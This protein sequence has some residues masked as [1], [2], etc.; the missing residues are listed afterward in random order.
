MLP[1]QINIVL[2][3]DDIDD[4]QFFK[5]ALEQL[6][7]TTHLTTVENGEEL[8]LLLSKDPTA[9][10]VVFLDLNMPRKNGFS[11][12][13]EIKRSEKLKSL[14]VIVLST[15]YD[16]RI[17]NQLNKNG[18]QMYASKPVESLELQKIIQLALV[19]VFQKINGKLCKSPI[20]DNI[21]GILP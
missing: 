11:C 13:E 9:F 19:L 3:D 12:L 1:Q 7:F 16:E 4:C 10:H 5:E 2:A 17:A 21:K 8:M 14:T 20:G 15:S 18:A 6:E